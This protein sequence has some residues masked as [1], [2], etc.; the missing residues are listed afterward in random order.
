MSALVNDPQS[1]QS[2]YAAQGTKQR[3]APGKS[4]DRI[5]IISGNSRKHKMSA[6]VNDP[7]SLQN[8]NA[9]RGTKQRGAPGKLSTLTLAV[10]AATS[11]LAFS[12]DNAKAKQITLEEV[13]V[14]AQKRSESLQDVPVAVSAIAGDDLLNSGFRDVGDIA[15]QVP[16]LIVTANDS[17]LSASFKIRRIGNEGNI[18]TFEPATALI[19][20]GAFRSRSGLGLGDLVDVRSVEVL[21]GPQSTLYGK[22]AGAG[23][24]SVTTQGPV[25]DFEGMGELSLGSEGYQAAKASLNLPLTD[26]MAARFSFSGSQRDPMM[27]NLVGPDADDMDGYAIRGQL[28][29]DFS[30]ALTSR[31]ILGHIVRDMH[32]QIGDTYNSPAQRSI[33]ENAGGPISNNDPKDRITEQHSR[34]NFELTSDDLVW[35]IDYAADG[36]S[37]TSIIG[38][39]DFDADIILDGVGQLPLNIITYNDRQAGSSFSH[40]LRIASDSASDFSWLLGTFYYDNELERGDKDRPEFVLNE[41]VEEY[42]GAVAGAL[43]GLPGIVDLPLLGVEGD[44]GDFFV[45]QDTKSLGVFG[46]LGRRIGESLELNLGLRYSD[47][48]KTAAIQQ[49]N[50]TSDSCL[51]PFD[52]TNFIC[53]LTPNGNDFA[54]KDDWTAVSGDVNISYFLSGGSMVYAS[55][56]RGFKSG[57]YSLEYGQASPDFRPFDEENITSY[58]LGWKSE[59][60]DRR[61]RVNGALFT[62]EYEDYQNATFVSLFYSVNNAERVDVDGIEVDTTW[63]VSEN[64]TASLNFAYIE[65]VY[66]EYSAG[67]CYYGR[68]PDNALGQCDLSGEGLPY[69]PELTSN[70]ALTWEQPVGSGDLYARMDYRYVDEYNSSSELDPRHEQSDYTLTNVRLGWRNAQFDVAVWVQN[71]SDTTY[72]VQSGPSN[73]A[74]SIDEAVGSEE[75]SYQ[76]F[77]GT[78]RTFGLTVRSYF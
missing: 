45:Q 13:V 38:Y 37:I 58:E 41:D 72:V 6:L 65:A 63:L 61:L 2:T 20:D 9:T 59:L 77:L 22:N 66:D 34:T 55:Y 39:E 73:V 56:S 57:G 1:L 74:T 71:L 28:R 29:Y 27:D 14:T 62:T 24:I 70:L 4:E 75:G 10:L 16:S 19:I 52:E 18:P 5:C 47:E 69:A 17:P 3:G 67:R 46:K 64:L 53:T 31:L 50:Q 35:S 32:P 76:N 36:Y 8:T 26:S 23:V 51:P 30:D 11:S 68:T 49:S 48:E 60:F 21:K 43:F 12:Q 25:D 15:A 54:D 7:Q 40:E 44:Y 33:L 78:P 42:G